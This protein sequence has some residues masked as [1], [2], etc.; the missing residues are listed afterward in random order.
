MSTG[1]SWSGSLSNLI[2][3]GRQST[4]AALDDLIKAWKELGDAEDEAQER[5]CRFALRVNLVAMPRET[6][7]RLGLR[8]S[9][10]LRLGQC[11]TN[12][13]VIAGACREIVEA[14]Q[15]AE[16]V[17]AVHGLLCR[18]DIEPRGVGRNR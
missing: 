17:E 5:F 3:S 15:D 1:G 9:H 13:D 18:L 7:R 4:R 11:Q 10:E 14:V 16:V 8:L 6:R 12:R 2:T